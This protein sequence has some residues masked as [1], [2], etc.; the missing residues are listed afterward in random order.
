[1]PKSD[2]RPRPENQGMSFQPDRLIPDNLKADRETLRKARLLVAISFTGFIW[3]PVFAPIHFYVGRSLQASIAL[4]VAGLA[5]MMMPFVLRASGGLKIPANLLCALL[6]CIVLEVTVVRGGYPVSALIWACVIPLLALFLLGRKP[7]V[8]WGLVVAAFFLGLGAFSLFGPGFAM[9]MSDRQMLAIDVAGITA[10][11]I[12]SGTIMW[13]YE[14]ERRRSLAAVEAADR[15]KTDFLARMSHEVRTPMHGVLGTIDLLLAT[16]LSGG[17][18]SYVGLIQKSSRELLRIVS[19]IL[20]FARIEKGSIPLEEGPFDPHKELEAAVR[21]FEPDARAK[22]VDLSCTME[23]PVPGALIGDSGKLQQVLVNLLSNAV[24]FT[25]AGSIEVTASV[26][27]VDRNQ[28]RMKV[29][30]TDTGRGIARKDLATIFEPFAQVDESMSR[31]HGGGGLGLSVSR[32]LVEILGGRLG[33]ESEPGLGSTFTFAVP[34]EAPDEGVVDTGTGP[35]RSAISEVGVESRDRRGGRHVLLA[36]DN[37][38]NKEVTLAMLRGLGYHAD[39]ASNGREAVEL[40][41]RHR[42]DLVLMDCQMPEMDGYE[43]TQELRALPGTAG[44]PIVALTAHALTTDRDRCL[45]AGM[46]DYL[47]KP[48]DSSDLEAVLVRWVR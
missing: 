30:V 36:E 17:Q 16:E 19:E 47:P 21:L 20:D 35:L 33:V 12:L 5:V 23:G 29:R 42:Y 6:L 40:V 27:S 46:D 32:Q 22:G 44:L 26:R 1:M 3:G 2:D 11:L 34:F 38:V 45:E 8:I 18:R 37:P 28:F 31:S 15:A 9:R 48:I 14:A 39:V 24:K 7:A 13:L 10:F 41:R 4:L 43:A 25:D